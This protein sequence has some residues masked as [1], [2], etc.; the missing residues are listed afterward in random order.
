MIKTIAIKEFSHIHSLSELKLE[1]KD[2]GHY[3]PMDHKI[4]NELLK[5]VT[6]HSK[7]II[8]SLSS[9]NV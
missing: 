4:Y 7:I 5:T 8:L 3:L 1:P 9:C 2:W 6:L